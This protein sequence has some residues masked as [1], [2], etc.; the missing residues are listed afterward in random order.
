MPTTRLRELKLKSV[1]PGPKLA[2]DF[3][4]SHPHRERQFGV[5]R[6]AM[7]LLRKNLDGDLA[8]QVGILGTI[9][10][11]HAA[12]ADAVALIS[13]GVLSG[14]DGRHCPASVVALR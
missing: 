13:W 12:L 10:F 6:A 14:C 8:A 3:A 5:A 11:S 1:L 9:H 4:L 7:E 2:L